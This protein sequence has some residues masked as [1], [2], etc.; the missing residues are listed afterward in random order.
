MSLEAKFGD[1]YEAF[2]RDITW[3]PGL[4]IE[5]YVSFIADDNGLD[6]PNGDMLITCAHNRS[7]VLDL[8]AC[9]LIFVKYILNLPPDM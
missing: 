6:T 3:S 7:Y 9:C 4:F 8:F 5:F 2:I 1:F